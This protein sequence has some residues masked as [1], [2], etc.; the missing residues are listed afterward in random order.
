MKLGIVILAAGKGT[1]MRSS[2]PKVLHKLAELP[3]LGHVIRAAEKLNPEVLSV[4][5]GHG[6]DLVQQAMQQHEV[7]WVE[8]TEQLGTGHAVQQVMSSMQDVDRVMVLY[9]DVP[10]IQSDTLQALMDACLQTDL[11][12]LTV[13]LD[14][15]T[16]YGRIVRNS[17]GQV[18]LIVEQKDASS[19]QLLLN[20][21]NTGI[22][23]ADQKK[24]SQ[25]LSGLENNNAQQEFYLTDVVAMAVAEG[26]L[27]N[28]VQPE[29]EQEVMGVNDR[30]QLA[31]LERYY[32]RQLATDCMTSGITLRDPARFD[33]RGELTHGTDIVIDVNVL[34]EGK[35]SIGSDC[36][37]GANT[38]IRNSR[39]GEGVTIL[40]NCVIDQ[41][42]VGD[43]C[44]IGPFS[45]LRPEA[46]LAKDC[47]VG[48]F[49][50]IK[51][52]QVGQGTKISHLSYIGDAIIGE[53]VNIGAGTITC[54]YDGVNKFQTVIGDRA[55]IGS[56]TQL[57]APVEIGDDAT[58]GAGSTIT[59]DTPSDEL[60]L[61]RAKQMT[62][63]GWSRP[64][65][66]H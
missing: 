41:A 24:L 42:V 63:K 17:E 23:I 45:R 12:L 57:V 53:Q 6:G 65:K 25:W 51:K 60:T 50:E 15:P 37:I 13:V 9:G 61:S 52:S 22:L 34:L 66:K 3:L 14:S 28:A 64:V 16:G 48:N 55:F 4:V 2:V 10:L 27:V 43:D 7:V 49:V 40:E 30:M 8:Q 18:Q 38:V 29:T 58:I 32:Q 31:V 39:I 19:E 11:S 26:V 44:V 1:R 20:E 33:L 21:V 56:D 54:N 36:Q 62:L 59:K 47:R 46:E 5:Y 35:L